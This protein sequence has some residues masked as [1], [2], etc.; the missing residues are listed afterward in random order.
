MLLDAVG[1][2]LQGR[3][4][5]ASNVIAT[6]PDHSEQ[7]PPETHRTKTVYICQGEYG[8]AS[9]GDDV[10]L[11]SSDATTC[12]LLALT[13]PNTGAAALAHYDSQHN[14]DLAPLLT[15]M[16]RPRAYM[17]GAF[18]NAGRPTLEA[19]LAAMDAAPQPITLEVAAV[20]ARNVDQHGCP[21]VTAMTIH[22]PTGAVWQ[23]FDRA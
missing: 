21:I 17:A 14:L 2:R 7:I 13:C 4:A 6:L 16:Q 12:V 22:A 1:N 23:G 3:E 10:Q 11:C 5:V 18:D 20:G 15:D 9:R 19:I 8:I